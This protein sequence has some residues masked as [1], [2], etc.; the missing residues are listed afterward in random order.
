MDEKDGALSIWPQ[1]GEANLSQLHLSLLTDSDYPDND[2]D[3][4]AVT[5]DNDDNDT[6][7]PVTM[8]WC[9]DGCY[10]QNI[11]NAMRNS[12][13]VTSFTKVAGLDFNLLS[14]MF[15]S[16]FRVQVLRF[17]RFN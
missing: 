2:N 8:Y 16:P 9:Q 10:S 6:G 3:D 1:S 12:K 15:G 7:C 11:C 14:S 17:I 5:K 4:D 13:N